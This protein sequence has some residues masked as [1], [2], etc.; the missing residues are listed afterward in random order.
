MKLQ[1]ILFYNTNVNVTDLTGFRALREGSF[2]ERERKEIMK[3]P[4]EC[5]V[6]QCQETFLRRIETGTNKLQFR[7]KNMETERY[8]SIEV[9]MHSEFCVIYGFVGFMISGKGGME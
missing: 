3:R 6:R 2:L 5:P 9:Y 4:N 1:E 8:S 7:H